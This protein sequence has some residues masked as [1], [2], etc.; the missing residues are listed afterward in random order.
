VPPVIERDPL[1]VHVSD[2]YQPWTHQRFFHECPAKYRLQVG[3][4]GSGK[5]KPLLIEGIVHAQEV[6]GSNNIILR[7]TIP[8]LKR[9]VIDKFLADIPKA[10][11]ERGSQEK[12]TYNQSDHI[13]YFPPQLQFNPDGSPK[14]GPG[15]KQESLQS[16]LFF[17][18][19][20]R[21][22]DVTKYLSTE[23]LFI[24]FEE[25]GEF[26]F[27]IWDAFT[28]RNRCPIPG[29]RP[30]MAGSTNPMG[31]GW[32][33]IKRL[34]IDKQPYFGMNPEKYNPKDYWFV[35][36]TVDQ[37][38]IYS[39]DREYMDTLEASPLRDKI[40][41]GKLDSVSGQYFDIWD[42]A[43]MVLPE[44][45]FIFEPWNPVWVGWDYGFG[46]F[47]TITWWTKAILKPRLPFHQ[48][49]LVNVCIGELALHEKTIEEQ[50]QEFIAMLPHIGKIINMKRLEERPIGVEDAFETDERDDL[51]PAPIESI[52]FSWERFIKTT[53]KAGL[54]RSVA[55]DL[56]DILALNNIVRPMRSNTDRVAGWS[57][58]Y[59]LLSTGELY[60]LR[61]KCPQLAEA[62]PLAV[63]GDGITCSLEDVVKPKG[64]SLE[65]DLNDSAR[66][67]VAGALLDEGEKPENIK[68]RDKLSGIKDPM[69][70]HV[71]MYKHFNKQR[72]TERRGPVGRTLPSWMHR[73]KEQ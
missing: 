39:K 12:G 37:N 58:I 73:V 51:I 45:A 66:Y 11:Y 55:D 36:S 46:H 60:L 64:L 19:C 20:E 7:K 61:G 26:P 18:A 6:P 69:R 2:Y 25:L 71:E 22:E 59:S 49:K 42:P 10:V 43:N 47:A 67:A 34:F 50:G 5:S 48:P 44:S 27:A 3:S 70:R 40:R 72:A 15:G 65:D 29:S 4:F 35:H 14:I 41:W 57:K 56:G 24:G 1:T 32:G 30:C 9:T 63:R 53:K 52:F 16:K 28:G 21:I 13:V 17:G 38:P 8:D 68:L 62:I 33:W 31:I 54:K 23:F